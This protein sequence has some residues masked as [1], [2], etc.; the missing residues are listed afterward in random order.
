MI[1]Q[2]PRLQHEDVDRPCLALYSPANNVASTTGSGSQSPM[3]DSETTLTPN[4][5]TCPQCHAKFSLQ[6]LEK[7]LLIHTSA[8]PC[9]LNDEPG[10]GET[11]KTERGQ[12]RHW[13]EACKYA[14]KK[15]LP[16]RCCCGKEV[17]RWDRLKKHAGQCLNSIHQ[18][19]DSQHICNCGARFE[20]WP[21]IKAHHES[22]HQKT[23][24]RPKKK[25]NR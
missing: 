11:F 18:F 20:T 2:L 4:L 12:Q 7:H 24:G 14:G 3:P 5:R 9:R 19:G 15:L 10:C 25:Q 17:K 6:A 16:Y 23:P 13:H 8:F 21:G 1:K 22:T